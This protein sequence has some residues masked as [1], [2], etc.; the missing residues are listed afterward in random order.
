[1]L[2][3]WLICNEFLAIVL[4]YLWIWVV[5]IGALRHENFYGNFA[6]QI[7]YGFCYLLRIPLIFLV[8]RERRKFSG[9][10]EMT[11]VDVERWR[12][13]VGYD[14]EGERKAALGKFRGRFYSRTIAKDMFHGNNLELKPYRGEGLLAKC[15]CVAPNA[16]L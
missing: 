5:S 1:M 4:S 10:R 16:N 2:G 8:W 14:R 15:E 6:I 9:E 12:T 3:Y 7:S 11:D 13:H